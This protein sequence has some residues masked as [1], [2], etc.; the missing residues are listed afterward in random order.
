MV[1]AEIDARA[2][3]N[4]RSLQS[5][6]SS[7]I[8]LKVRQ[9]F[10]MKRTCSRSPLTMRSKGA[11]PLRMRIIRFG[12]HVGSIGSKADLD[13]R[14]SGRVGIIPVANI[15]MMMPWRISPSA[16]G[17]LLFVTNLDSRVPGV[18]VL[19]ALDGSYVRAFCEGSELMPLA[20]CVHHQLLLVAE[21]DQIHVIDIPSESLV[22]TIGRAGNGD[23]DGELDG[24]AGM[25]VSGDLLFVCETLAHFRQ[26][27]SRV[28]VFQLSTGEFLRTF[29]AQGSGSAEM[30]DL[31]GMCLSPDGELLFVADGGNHCVHVFRAAD[32]AHVRTIGSKG[33]DDGQFNYPYDVCVSPSGEWLFVAE[34]RNKRVQVLSASDGTYARTL[35]EDVVNKPMGMCVAAQGASN[36]L[37]V[38]DCIGF[39]RIH[40]FS[41]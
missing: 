3:K 20:I 35:G 36:L 9:V 31:T 40:A 10:S 11:A 5:P 7:F 38:T 28:S 12:D 2:L 18:H 32:G 19:N 41:L 17:A 23:G 22:R 29:G 24:P 8:N 25:C 27:S 39:D 26:R 6:P 16:D 30:S 21:S 4:R 34:L 1:D 13:R 37:Y 15:M 14:L 33:N